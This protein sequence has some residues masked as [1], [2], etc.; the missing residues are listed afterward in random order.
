MNYISW[1]HYEAEKDKA[2][3]K[4]FLGFGLVFFGALVLVGLAVLIF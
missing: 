2:W 1:E 3:I 4:D